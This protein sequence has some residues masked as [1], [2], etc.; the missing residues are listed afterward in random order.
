M[1]HLGLKNKSIRL[2]FA[3]LNAKEKFIR[4]WLEKKATKEV[5]EKG[6]YDIP[7]VINNFNR[8][9]AMVK[10]IDWLRNAGHK[11]IIILDNQS[12]YPP[13]LEY[14]RQNTFCTVIHLG[15]NLGHK[16]LWKSGVY[17]KIRNGYFC[18]T[19]PDLVPVA[20]CPEN[21]VSHL[22]ELLCRYPNVVK[23]GSGLRISDIPDHYE[24]KDRVVVWESR[25]W[26]NP[27]E[28][29][30]YNA[31]LDTTFAIYR[32]RTLHNTHFPALRTGEPYV[33]HHTPWYEDVDRLTE[34]EL[35]YR[36]K[37]SGISWWSDSTSIGVDKINKIL[38]LG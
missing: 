20:E 16:A 10:L 11:N 1:L 18:Y 7:I 33:M 32:P 34:E 22:F 2:L 26:Q 36:N 9:N 25:Y 4:F 8:Y 29:N 35:F 37:S 17:K 13:L 21:L 28:E 3:M 19:D 31:D 14:Y 6:V 24:H 12:T 27:V 5:R 30:V 23:V 15:A 38:G